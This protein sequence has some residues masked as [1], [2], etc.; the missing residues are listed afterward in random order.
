MLID[1]DLLLRAAAAHPTDP[2]P[3]LIF[4]DWL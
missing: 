4:A 1:R 2:F 3:R